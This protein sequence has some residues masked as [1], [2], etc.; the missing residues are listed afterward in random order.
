MTVL[1]T[2]PS[3]PIVAAGTIFP[4][5]VIYV[6]LT[7][8][9]AVDDQ[10]GSVARPFSTLGAAVAAANALTEST[11]LLPPGTYD[12]SASFDFVESVSLVAV[13]GALVTAAGG[14]YN[15]YAVSNVVIDGD[16]TFARDASISGIF[17]PG[18]IDSASNLTID[19]CQISR[20]TGGN[21][22]GRGLGSAIDGNAP[23]NASRIRFIA[24]ALTVN[25][26]DYYIDSISCE[27]LLLDGC[28]YS[29]ITTTVSLELYSSYGVFTPTID[30]TGSTSAL[31][32]AVSYGS[33]RADSNSVVIDPAILT[34]RQ[35][36]GWQLTVT[37]AVPALAAGALDYVE[38]PNPFAALEL[39][40]D[41]VVVACPKTDVAAAGANGGFFA[42]VRAT[43]G[44]A[45]RFAFKG[46][47][48]AG[49]VDFTVAFLT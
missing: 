17:V 16:I 37:V 29:N 34:V 44:G 36:L 35:S 2:S 22:F 11:I 45:L 41:D 28:T 47:T 1:R 6:D 39:T 20:I 7:T 32:D 26:V 15:T 48:L 46:T 9:V 18:N 30:T 40:E 21:V 24:S 3:G 43:A 5:T 8:P 38:V 27:R 25:L 33:I 49:N 13:G 19:A 4:G 10:D 23:R 31:L 42:G 14:L 12:D